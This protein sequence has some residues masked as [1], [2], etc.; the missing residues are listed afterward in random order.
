MSRSRKVHHWFAR[1]RDIAIAIM[2]VHLRL[3][4]LHTI[5]MATCGKTPRRA[6]EAITSQ[7]IIKYMIAIA[8]SL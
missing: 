6:I 7:P 2:H 5:A 3:L 1:A 4:A 8:I